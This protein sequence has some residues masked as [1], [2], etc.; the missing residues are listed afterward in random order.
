MKKMKGLKRVMAMLLAVIMVLGTVNLPTLA[1]DVTYDTE[2]SRIQ[3]RDGSG[4]LLIFPN[5]HDYASA[6]ATTSINNMDSIYNT[7]SKIVLYKSDTEYGV[8]ADLMVAEGATG[9]SGERYYNI[10][11]ETGS[12]AID[13]PDGWDGTTIKKIVFLAGC[14]LPAYAHTNG[15]TDTKTSYVLQDNF[16]FTTNTSNQSNTDWTCMKGLDTDISTLQIRDASDKLLIFPTVHDYQNAGAATTITSM[17]NTY[18]TLSN[19]VLYKSD[20][21]FSTLADLF[22]A[23]AAGS[24]GERYYNIWGETGSVAIDMPDGWDGTTIKKIVFKAG[25]ELPSYQY[26]N[27]GGTTK[28]CYYL[29]DDAVFTTNTSAQDNTDWTR[30]INQKVIDVEISKM[31]IRD[32]SGKL[33]IYPSTHDYAAAGA[34]TSIENWDTT[35][36]TFENIVLYKSDSEF[37]TLATLMVQT[38]ASGERYYNIWGETGSVAVDLPDGWDG[39]T[40]KKV[41][42]KAGCQFPSY[43]YTNGGETV[44]LSYVLAEDC[45]FVTNT[46]ATDNTDWSP[47]S[48]I[49]STDVVT[50]IKVNTATILG[51]T[52]DKISSYPSDGNFQKVDESSVFTYTR[53]GVTTDCTAVPR[54]SGSN[55]CICLVLSEITA[56][57]SATA[58]DIIELSGIWYYSVDTKYYNFGT[59]KYEFNGTA[60]EVWEPDYNE[61][62]LTFTKYVSHSG[63]FTLETAA[64]ANP[65]ADQLFTAVSSDAA[66]TY[67]SVATKGTVRMTSIGLILSVSEMTGGAQSAANENDIVKL[68][69]IWQYTDGKYYDF[70]TVEYKWN[71]SDW[72]DVNAPQDIDT[73]ISGVMIYDTSGKLIIQPSV[74]D[75]NSAA[76]SFGIKDAALAKLKE[77]NFFDKIKLSTNGATKTLRQV[78][79]GADEYYYN[80]WSDGSIVIDM[81]DEWDA[82]TVTM[83][84]I[85][86]GCEFPAYAYTNGDSAV[87]VSYKTTEETSW[88]LGSV[89]SEYNATYVRYYPDVVKTTTVTNIHVRSQRLLVFLSNNDYAEAASTTEATASTL[90]LYNFLDNIV[91]VS[92]NGT[93]TLRELVEKDENDDPRYLYNVWGESNCISIP[94]TAGW[95]GDTVTS[96]LVK[97]GAEFPSYAYTSGATTDHIKYVTA[98]DIEFR[99]PQLPETGTSNTSWTSAEP[100]TEEVQVTAVWSGHNGNLVTFSLSDSDYDGLATYEIGDKHTEYNYLD[101]IRVYN[102]SGECASLKTAYA[103]EKYYNLFGIGNSVSLSFMG[104][105][106]TLSDVTRI[107]IP[108][109]TVFPAYAY[110][111]GAP[112][113]GTFVDGSVA[114]RAGYEVT[115]ELVFEKGSDTFTF[116]EASGTSWTDIST[117]D[118][119]VPADVNGDGGVSA[120]DIVTM[121]KYLANGYHANETSD[122]N[123]D[124]RT[125]ETDLDLLKEVILGRVLHNYKKESSSTP[126]FSSSNSA[127]DDFL[128]DYFKRHVGYV[129]YV[130]GDMTVNSYKVGS[131]Y[132]GIFNTSWNTMATTWFDSSAVGLSFDRTEAMKNIIDNVV[133]DRYGYV[134]DGSD[135]VEETTRDLA[136]ATH[137]MGWTFPNANNGN[138]E[139]TDRYWDFNKVFDVGIGGSDS[140][141]WTSSMSDAAVTEGAGVYQGTASGASSVTFTVKDYAILDAS[142]EAIIET[143]YAPWLA[144]DVRMTGVTNPENIDDIYIT[145]KTGNNYSDAVSYTVKASDIA[146]MTYD[147]GTEYAHALWLPM[148]TQSN[149]DNASVYEIT[150]EIRANSRTTFGGTFGLNYVRPWFD[151]RHSN[152]NAEYLASLKSYYSMTGDTAFVEEHIGDARRAMTFYMQ[153]YDTDMDLNKQSYLY[154]H[155]GSTTEL[156]NSLGNGYWDVLYTPVYDFQSNLYFYQ[157]LQD[158]LY[159]EELVEDG[160]ATVNTAEV[161]TYTIGSASYSSYNLQ[162]T[163]SELLAKMR[164][165]FWDSTDGRFI[166]GFDNSGNAV[167]Y[168]YTTWNLQAI[169]AGIATEEQAQSIITWLN[170]AE[171]DVTN[172]TTETSIYQFGFAPR[173]NSV[174]GAKENYYQYVVQS[175]LTSVYDLAYGKNVQYGGAA[176][177]TSYYDLMSR[178]QVSGANDAYDRLTSIGNWY[179]SVQTAF[180]TSENTNRN[181][182]KAYFDNQG[183]TMQDGVAGT[184]NGA[185]GIDGEFTESLLVAAAIP[186]GFFGISSDDGKCLNVAP[187][188]PEDL[189]FWK[190]ENMA[191]N[192]VKYDVSIYEDAVR[193]DSVSGD[194]TGLTIRITLNCA[195]GQSVYVDG[196]KVETTARDADGKVEIT[197]PFKEV[198]VEVKGVD[199][200]FVAEPA[201]L[202][203]FVVNVE[204]GREARVLQLTDTQIIDAAQARTADEGTVDTEFNKIGNLDA[205]VFD[206]MDAV[207][208]EANPDLILVTGDLIY[209]KFDDNGT[210]LQAFIEKM[211]SYKIPWAPI[212]GNHENE[213]IKG[214]DWQCAQLEASSYCLFKQ[215]D[216]T[217]NGN[218]SVGIAQDGKLVRTFFMMDT[219]GCVDMSAETEA[220]GH[221]SKSYGFGQDQIDWLTSAAT[222]IRQESPATKISMAFHIQ[223]S[224]WDDA[225]ATYGYDAATIKANPINLDTNTTAQA[226]GDF[227][228]IGRATKNPWDT[229]G[230]VWAL[231]KSLGVD[232]IFVGHEHCNSAS[233][234]YDGIRVTYG[235][236]T[237]VYDRAN[238]ELT[239]GTIAGYY[240]GGAPAGATP[241][242]GGTKI[243]VATNGNATVNHV[244]YNK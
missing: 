165:Y 95:S 141:V 115:H 151:T 94:L 118:S 202:V 175:Q 16:V 88:S 72:V 85:E 230:N 154:G 101:M 190:I 229:T 27:N 78:L 232:S 243:T 206:C 103:G 157:A 43:G 100:R 233:I 77:Y 9:V 59:K 238:Y 237:G 3:V 54:V 181:F 227:G 92:A 116:G 244:Y 62:L 11:G 123:D 37:S 41:V 64:I 114:A 128:N 199:N 32:G 73:G 235:L 46:S 167:D 121:K 67:N 234:K 193:L 112:F 23:G 136:N 110:T 38:G 107:V 18:N 239:D 124:Y 216:L 83:I 79:G 200:T 71:G 58:G 42:F 14:E 231:F 89:A 164:D 179:Q 80:L 214:A 209:G 215:R 104:E 17:D 150:I 82:K 29:A 20:S 63:A 106:Y 130:D 74:S 76:S 188:M 61:T 28:T 221:S 147:F 108:A 96:V 44:K 140:D 171:T 33:L 126:I 39:T 222:R 8:L 149:W 217:G 57:S 240:G 109:G 198:I 105:G 81:N 120:V 228:Y 220:N 223:M 155:N 111:G 56:Y 68:T 75:Y 119:D 197:I 161:S 25:C 208:A 131:Y 212:F 183:I 4:K 169:E 226:N 30:Q 132:N 173:T 205:N 113:Q 192:D 26:T 186:Y 91:L 146:A 84:T 242:I 90:G 5:T 172:A 125:D 34:T 143:K 49:E 170:T 166:A 13:M 144:V 129:D 55:A 87:K 97:A 211:D 1:A 50:S 176:M 2:I 24:S 210:V 158:M 196:V 153:M 203:D 48:V 185:V 156:W 145:Y 142:R 236:K 219:N 184:G 6:G 204:S 162:T 218:Y 182:Y 102:K 36:N 99:T 66:V 241:I 12:I 19:I 187:S 47:A 31:A 15:G 159:L 168:G 177:F 225:M 180:E 224:A 195:D 70:G 60:W 40:I 207:V 178:L 52:A 122:C 213:S 160:D 201:D 127:L 139:G 51:L 194:T 53:D 133:I 93:K 135:A 134:W 163:A 174:E 191:F 189:H 137:S 10:W 7:L 138:D 86:N 98:T 148:Y 69:G 22:A 45:A 35:Y 152:N 117:G 65:T 21:E